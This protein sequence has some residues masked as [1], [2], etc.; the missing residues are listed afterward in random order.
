MYQK[1]NFSKVIEEC[2]KKSI[3][4]D[5]KMTKTELIYLLETFDESEMW[6]VKHLQLLKHETIKEWCKWFGIETEYLTHLHI[7]MKLE[8]YHEIRKER[9]KYQEK[10]K[11]NKSLLYHWRTNSIEFVNPLFLKFLAKCLN[12]QNRSLIHNHNHLANTLHRYFV[13]GDFSIQKLMCFTKKQLFEICKQYEIKYKKNQLKADIVN[14]I[15]E[16]KC[17]EQDN[18][19]KIIIS[20]INT[21]TDFCYLLRN[22]ILPQVQSIINN[23]HTILYLQ[24]N[25]PLLSIEEMNPYHLKNILKENPGTNFF[26]EY[27]KFTEELLH[28]YRDVIDWIFIASKSCSRNS[29][30]FLIQYLKYFDWKLINKFINYHKIH[31]NRYPWTKFPSHRLKSIKQRCGPIFWD[32]F[33]KYYYYL[34]ENDTYKKICGNSN[35]YSF[36]LNSFIDN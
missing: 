8:K 24:F 11:I 31:Y 21:R 20:L 34:Y 14:N 4:I 3:A 2:N 5:F 7:M 1:L 15:A 23:E 27:E 6:S 35:I 12:I 30:E 13:S 33:C 19:V 22:N 17:K 25:L 28:E 18:M 36:E 9:K 16:K 29:Y 32:A 10:T 26:I